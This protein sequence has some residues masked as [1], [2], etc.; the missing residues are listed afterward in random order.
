MVGGD[1]FRSPRGDHMNRVAQRVLLA[2]TLLS[3]LALGQ[4]PSRVAPVA[5][6]AASPPAFYFHGTPADQ[7]KKA[8]VPG[9]TAT[10]D[11]KPPAGTVRISQTISPS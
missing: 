1:T 5:A 6:D 8:T 3:V 2:L 4:A 7:A 11:G 9:G 10:F